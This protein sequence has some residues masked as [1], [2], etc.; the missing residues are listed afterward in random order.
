M[1]NDDRNVTILRETPSLT[2]AVMCRRDGAGRGGGLT[3]MGRPGA[4]AKR[5][6][7]ARLG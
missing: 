4:E 2:T 3:G 1:Q 5:Q 6:T 7:H